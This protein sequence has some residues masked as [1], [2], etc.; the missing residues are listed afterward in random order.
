M[1]FLRLLAILAALFSAGINAWL[2]YR[3]RRE[4]DLLVVGHSL[5]G[6]GAVIVFCLDLLETINIADVWLFGL[7][8]SFVLLSGKAII[9]LR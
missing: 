3:F 2:F 1:T 6:A 5:L 8:I 9:S 4:F 7:I